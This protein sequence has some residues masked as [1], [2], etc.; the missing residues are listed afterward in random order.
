MRRVEQWARKHG[1][2][3]V[4]LRSNVARKDAHAFYQSLGYNLVKTQHVFQKNL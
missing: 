2:K 1:C 3:S 4:N